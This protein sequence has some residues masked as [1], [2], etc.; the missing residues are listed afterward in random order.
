MVNKQFGEMATFAPIKYSSEHS[1]AIFTDGESEEAVKEYIENNI[2]DVFFTKTQDWEYEQEL[3]ILIK[4]RGKEEYLH[5]GEDAL[6]AAILCLP[7]VSNYKE[8][9]EFKILKS[10]LADIPIL[11]Y[12]TSLGNKELLDEHG[13]KVC[14]IPGEDLQILYE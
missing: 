3:R 6:V 8:S 9:P 13:K 5:Y 12:T 2:E 1:N 14:D 7:H 10:I 4:G 11:H